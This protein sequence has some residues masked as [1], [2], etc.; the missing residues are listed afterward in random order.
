MLRASS[1]R[2]DLQI[3]GTIR[4]RVERAAREKPRDER[5]A[6]SRR[7]SLSYIRDEG[8]D[9]AGSGVSRRGSPRELVFFIAQEAVK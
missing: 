9:A 6:R 2:D 8:R 5:V 4:S 1:K 7:Y 3:A